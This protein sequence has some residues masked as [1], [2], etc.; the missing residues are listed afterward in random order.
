MTKSMLV[1]S[2]IWGVFIKGT[3]VLYGFLLFAYCCYKGALP[4]GICLISSIVLIVLYLYLT[5]QETIWLCGF[6]R[7]VDPKTHKYEIK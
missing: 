6:W 2:Y 3:V 7:E 1:L 5:I 4:S